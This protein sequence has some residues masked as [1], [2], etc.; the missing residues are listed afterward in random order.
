MFCSPFFLRQIRNFS[1]L[2]PKFLLKLKQPNISIQ[3]E[4]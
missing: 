4:L 2:S 3:N 1:T